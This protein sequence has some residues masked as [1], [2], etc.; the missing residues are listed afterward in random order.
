MKSKGDIK[1]FLWLLAFFVFVF[2]GQDAMAQFE[3]EGYSFVQK[4]KTPRAR[5]PEVHELMLDP[6][7]RFLI[8][9]FSSHP[10]HILLY[11]IN[12]WELYKEYMV[13]EWFDLSNSFVDPEGRFLFVDFG[14]FSSRYRRI[15]LT[16]DKID[17]VDCKS[18]P[19]GCLPKEPTQPKRDLF[20]PDKKFYITIN[21]KNRRDVLV[22][23]KND[24]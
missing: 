18:T 22:F 7:G 1:L 17:T 24:N 20:T 14:R 12:S 2:S 19:R 3:K 9:T 8:L 10:T 4:L 21:R 5:K 16:T 6:H 11:Q 13:P 23:I 15:D